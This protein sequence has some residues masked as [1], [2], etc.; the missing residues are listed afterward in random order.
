M[1]YLKWRKID[2]YKRDQN[3]TQREKKKSKETETS[4][5]GATV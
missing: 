1:M 5:N 2:S 3:K 4:S